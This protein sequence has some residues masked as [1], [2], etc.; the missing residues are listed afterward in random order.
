MTIKLNYDQQSS[1]KKAAMKKGERETR[2]GNVELITL[3]VAEKPW[4]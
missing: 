1:V 2:T 3:R 4:Q